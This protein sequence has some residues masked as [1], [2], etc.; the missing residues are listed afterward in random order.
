MLLAAG[1]FPKQ[2]PN[3]DSLPC[4]NKTW[5]ACKTN[6]RSHQL[7]PKHEQQATGERGDVFGSAAAVISIHGIT[8]A[9]ATPG[10]PITPSALAFHAASGTSTTPA[11]D[12]ALQALDGHLDRMADNATN[13]GLTLSQLTDA[14][15]RLATTT[16]TKYQTIKKLLTD[17]ILSSSSPNPRSSSTGTGAGTTG[18]QQTIRLIQATIKIAGSSA[19]SDPPTDGE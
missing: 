10:A 8:G 5:A 11:G 17:I 16:S 13:S 3:W 2:L 9:T 19:G 14:N 18:D 4:A 15:A 1:T 6:F 12:F 7:T